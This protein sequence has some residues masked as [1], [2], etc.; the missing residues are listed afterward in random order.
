MT[1]INEST[2]KRFA[3]INRDPTERDVVAE[4]A[5]RRRRGIMNRVARQATRLVLGGNVA[6]LRGHFTHGLADNPDT[7]KVSHSAYGLPCTQRLMLAMFPD[8]SS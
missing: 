2:F 3:E 4:V 1:A 8:P 6:P 7:L 5:P